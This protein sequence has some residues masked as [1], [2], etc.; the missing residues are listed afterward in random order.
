M[1]NGLTHVGQLRL[2]ASSLLRRVGLHFL[3]DT[4]DGGVGC[5]LQ[6]PLTIIH[7]GKALFLLLLHGLPYLDLVLDLGLDPTQLSS[8]VD[9]LLKLLTGR[10]RLFVLL[11]DASHHSG[12]IL[13]RSVRTWR[14]VEAL[15]RD[16]HVSLVASHV[17]QR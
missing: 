7:V 10:L 11:R 12:L 8:R 17:L 13:L 4:L 1:T 9:Y 6:V 5:N 15:A 14:H 16:T 2:P 3:V